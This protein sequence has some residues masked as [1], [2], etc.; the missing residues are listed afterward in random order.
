MGG[1]GTGVM[2]LHSAH[3]Q[4]NKSNYIYDIIQQD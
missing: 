2:A 3:A 4:S 1:H